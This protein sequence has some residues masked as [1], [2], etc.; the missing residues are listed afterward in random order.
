MSPGSA[1]LYALPKATLLCLATLLRHTQKSGLK[2]ALALPF[3]TREGASSESRGDY[4]FVSVLSLSWTVPSESPPQAWGRGEKAVMEPAKLLVVEDNEDNRQILMLRL[5][6]TGAYD[7]RE[8]T[9]GQEALECLAQ[10]PPDAI[11]L[12]LKLP[13]LDGW[14]TARRIRTLPA[15]LNAL[16]I[17]AVTAHA[18]LEDRDRALAAGCDEYIAK[19]IDFRE[20]QEL[21]KRLLTR[22]RP[23]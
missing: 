21:L 13:V 8:A 5:R 15:P 23:A 19:P 12:D 18:M 2:N 1:S 6:H 3:A 7:V 4:P 20:L 11:L 9:N 10:D 16:P 17:I 14:E 22:R